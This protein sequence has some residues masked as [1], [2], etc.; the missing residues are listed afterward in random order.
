MTTRRANL[1]TWAAT[2]T[3]ATTTT[4]TVT[5]ALIGVHGS[6][7][8]IAGRAATPAVEAETS[9]ART[10]QTYSVPTCEQRRLGGTMCAV[11]ILIR[12]T[13]RTAASPI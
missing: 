7:L 12:L 6:A 10:C 13:S 9:N 4:T 1:S 2:V 8:L 5:I 11:P 3:A